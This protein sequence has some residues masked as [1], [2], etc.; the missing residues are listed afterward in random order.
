MFFW[1]TIVNREGSPFILSNRYFWL[2]F[3][4]L[5]RYSYAVTD[6][7]RDP[8]IPDLVGLQEAAEIMG[9]SKQAAHKMVRKAQLKGARIGNSTT[10]VFR[11]VVV[12]AMPKHPKS[13]DGQ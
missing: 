10:W 4:N 2:T 7:P 11:R 13:D 6:P 3:M 5:D 8:R 9:V 1:F 12:D